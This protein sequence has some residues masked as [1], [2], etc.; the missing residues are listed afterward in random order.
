MVTSSLS[1]PYACGLYDASTQMLYMWNACGTE[2]YHDADEHGEALT[3]RRVTQNRRESFPFI[4][5]RK[6]PTA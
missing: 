2:E 1:Y 6:S 4:V 5:K 3:H